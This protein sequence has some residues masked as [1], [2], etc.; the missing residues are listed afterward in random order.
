[1]AE[2]VTD[3]TPH[4]EEIQPPA[5]AHV[6]MIFVDVLREMR[7]QREALERMHQSAENDRLAAAK[8]RRRMERWKFILRAL[9]YGSPVVLGLLYFAYF[10]IST[11]DLSLGPINEVVGVVRIKGEIGAGTAAGADKVVPALRKAFESDRVKAVV[12]DIDSPG[13]A[14]LETERIYAA[15]AELKAKN[16]KQVIAVI[17]NVGASAAYMLAAHTDSIVAGKYSLVGSI[18]VIIEGWDLHKAAKRLEVG[19]RVFTS[20]SLKSMLH[21]FLPMTAEAEKKAKELVVDGGAAFLEEV[22][23]ARGSKLQAAVD[24]GSG[25]VWYGAQALKIGLI[26]EIGTLDGVIAK[27]WKLPMH[28]FGP[29]QKS[30]S[31]LSSL[32]EPFAEALFQRL[33]ALAEMSFR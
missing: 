8:E 4:A 17:E 7:A 16:P 33:T 14:P 18:G 26:D 28:Q 12:L 25:E 19:Q 3:S 5:P 27:K 22:R 6:G 32:V 9:L 21:P 20:G 13:G 10:V 15:I 11:S 31:L 23:A 29:A 30:N 2:S 1:M 24:Y